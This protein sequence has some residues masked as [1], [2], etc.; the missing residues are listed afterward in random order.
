MKGTDFRETLKSLGLTQ[1]EA[2][3][4]FGFEQRS[5]RR[6]V[7]GKRDVPYFLV[8]MLRMMVSGTIDPDDIGPDHQGRR[9][10]P[11]HPASTPLANW[12]V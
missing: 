6:W 1:A 3:R 10:A 12:P 9:V 5:S 2:A 7:S 8:I 11:E 4:L